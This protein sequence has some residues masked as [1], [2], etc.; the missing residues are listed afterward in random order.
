MGTKPSLLLA[1]PGRASSLRI[2]LGGIQSASHYCLSLAERRTNII[3][4]KEAEA[5]TEESSTDKED[6]C[7]PGKRQT[8]VDLR[9]T[10]ESFHKS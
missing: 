4:N 10:W 2:Y 3:K 1:L 5:H 9:F 7:D 6:L 8:T